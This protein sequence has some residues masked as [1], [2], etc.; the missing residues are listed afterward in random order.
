[1]NIRFMPY[2]DEHLGGV[3][4]LIVPIQQD[5]FGI[6]ITYEDQ[7]DLQNISEFYGR[8]IGNFW[9]AMDGAHVI[10]SIALLDI[11]NHQAAIRKMF[12]KRRFRGSTH[13][14][15]GGLL[16]R[17]LDHATE[18]EVHEIYLGTTDKFLA[19]HRFY[20]KA[21]FELVADYDLPGNFPRMS[22]DTRFYRLSLATT[23]P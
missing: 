7:P 17:L 8:G 11:G 10:G 6:E 16:R 3:R 5:E 18:N 12:V 15:A 2:A 22:V 14:V 13:G 20:E 9:V 23:P 21:G 19:A 4:D 1:M